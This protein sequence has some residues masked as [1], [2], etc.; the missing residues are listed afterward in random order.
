MTLW[1]FGWVPRGHAFFSFVW[2][3][4]CAIIVGEE[5]HV[6]REIVMPRFSVVVPAFNGAAH[7]AECLESVL[8]QG[9]DDLEV[10]VA[11]DRS[12]DETPTLVRALAERDPRVRLVERAE[13][14]GTRWVTVG[15]MAVLS[16]EA[17]SKHGYKPS[18]V[19]FDELHAQPN[20]DLWDVMTAG[21][22]SGRKQP[23]WIVLTTAGDDPDRTSIGWEIHQ[24]AVAIRDARRLR[25]ILAEGGDPRQVLSLR[26]VDDEDLPQAEEELLAQDMPNWLPILYGLT[27]LYGDDPDDLAAVDIWDEKL[28]FLCNP[29]LGKHLSL[30][31]IQLEAMEARRSE[32]GEKLFRWLRL[33]QWISVKAVSWISL[34]LYDKTQWG[35]S[36]RAERA[37]WLEQLKGK[38]CYG[39]VDLSTSKDLTAFVLL[40]PP[41]PGLETA[42]L[43]PYIWRP[44]ATAEEA[45][46]RDHVPY[47]DWARAG[48][49]QLCDGDIINYSDVEE[50]I[51]QAREDYDLRMVGFDPYLSRTITQRLEPIVPV[52][53]IPQDLRNMSPAMKETD[54]LMTR[55]QLLH[56]HN[57]CFRWTFGNVRCYVD[58]NGNIKPLKNKSTGRIDPTVASII[59][60]AVWMI[61][62]NQKP[63]LAEAMARPGYSL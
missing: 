55:H 45:E 43:L 39:G 14:G 4:S 46:R 42:V 24:K 44:G 19:I 40:F 16:A 29:S 33:N 27:A 20:R 30:R 35:P 9:V 12:S 25:R 22:G 60:V 31:N 5:L 3:G 10:I 38:L 13:N 59:A 37:A 56:V 51:R 52:M 48:F 53:E 21:A 58:G 61:M 7:I 36:K 62:R 57:T 47:R 50:A 11:D 18:C 26:H 32:A 41:Q 17:Y 54:D 2:R 23:V 28:W 6:G 63:D 34:T 49:L 15:L 1:R 8:S